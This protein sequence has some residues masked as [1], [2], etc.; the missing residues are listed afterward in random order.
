[1]VNRPTQSRLEGG[2]KKG[3]DRDGFACAA[4]GRAAGRL[5]DQERKVR[6]KIVRAVARPAVSFVPCACFSFR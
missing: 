6:G 3:A 2:E 1:M 5:M 4:H